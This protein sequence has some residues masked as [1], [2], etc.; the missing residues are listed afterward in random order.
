MLFVKQQYFA[1]IAFASRCP[2]SVD[3]WVVF[4]IVIGGVKDKGRWASC[5]VFIHNAFIMPNRDT[6]VSL[7]K[8]NCQCAIVGNV[9]KFN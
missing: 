9:P 4:W 5:K 1:I 6:A 8:G 3:V 7:V 2:L